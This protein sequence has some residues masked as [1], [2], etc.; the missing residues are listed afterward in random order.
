M[1]TDMIVVCI[2]IPGLQA[3]SL[4]LIGWTTYLLF[5]KSGEAVV[6]FLTV[7]VHK[8]CVICLYNLGVFRLHSW[9]F[10]HVTVNKKQ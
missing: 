10:C 1:S 4:T 9:A 6:F 8:S 5:N 2:Q 7:F 3:Y